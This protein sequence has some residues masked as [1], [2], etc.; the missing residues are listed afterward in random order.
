MIPRYNPMQTVFSMGTS[1]L[2]YMNYDLCPND[3]GLHP[4]LQQYF[5]GSQC[6]N[7]ESDVDFSNFPWLPDSDYSVNQS[8]YQ[9]GYGNCGNLEDFHA[10]SSLGGGSIH[11][12]SCSEHSCGREA[13]KTEKKLVKRKAGEMHGADDDDIDRRERNRLNAKKAR[14]RKK[15]L[16]GSLQGKLAALKGENSKLRRVIAARIP[17]KSVI[18]LNKSADLT[19]VL[20]AAANAP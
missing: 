11:S 1:G 15:L 7:G 16:F 20:A 8:Q 18:L 2:Q 5:G 6:Q 12:D 9:V 19:D 14:I 4:D 3:S 10:P 17:E 13:D